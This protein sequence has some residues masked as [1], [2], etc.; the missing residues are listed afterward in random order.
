MRNALA[1][2]FNFAAGLAIIAIPAGAYNCTLATPWPGIANCTVQCDPNAVLTRTDATANNWWEYTNLDNF[3]VMGYGTWI[4]NSVATGSANGNFVLATL[5]G[6]TAIK[7]MIGGQFQVNLENFKGDNWFFAQLNSAVACNF[8]FKSGRIWDYCSF[9]SRAGNC[10]GPANIG[11]PSFPISLVG[12]SNGTG[13]GRVCDWHIGKVVSNIPHIKGFIRIWQGVERVFLDSPYCKANGTIGISPSSGAYGILIGNE[14]SAHLGA[15]DPDLIFVRA[16]VFLNPFDAMIYL[17]NSGSSTV[18]GTG[19]ITIDC[20]GGL[21]EN[22]SDTDDVTIYKAAIAAAGVGQLTLLNVSAQACFNG[23]ELSMCP[24][25]TLTIDGGDILESIQYGLRISTICASGHS[26][27]PINIRLGRVTSSVVDSVGILFSEP[28]AGASY[29]PTSVV[30][31]QID[32][33]RIGIDIRCATPHA[34]FESFYW[35]CPDMRGC[36]VAYLA[37]AS[38][39]SPIAWDNVHT[40]RGTTAGNYGPRFAIEGCTDLRVGVTTFSGVTSGD[41]PAWNGATD[42]TSI[43]AGVFTSSNAVQFIDCPANRRASA[44]GFGTVLPTNSGVAGNYNQ[45]LIWSSDADPSG[46]RCSG[47]TNWNPVYDRNILAGTGAIL[48]G[49]TSVV[50]TH[51]LG[52]AP[53]Q[54]SAVATATTT[55]PVY[56]SF[57]DTITT[58]QMTVHC[59]TDPGTST[60]AFRWNVSA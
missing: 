59:N 52:V 57:I 58:T 25:E 60:L 51:N 55:N 16:P 15:T 34:A 50:I 38:N 41:S 39:T 49:A 35:S 29:G 32:I 33:P 30:V 31:G 4:G 21:G 5:D 18:G 54:Y 20:G 8:D 53:T 56:I 6:S 40:Y 43:A 48:N 28:L 13:T 27:G 37:S 17:V 1:F 10:R 22:Q 7:D 26:T 3:S 44:S 42:G 45:N 23:I 9:T 47:T 2:V 14:D 46:W 24:D 19:R 11:I 36:A 12:P